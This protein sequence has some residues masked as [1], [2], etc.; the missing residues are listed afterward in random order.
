[1]THSTLLACECGAGLSV[2]TGAIAGVWL[3]AG[4]RRT[5]LIN[6]KFV[7][8]RIDFALKIYVH[9]PQYK[10]SHLILFSRKI[11]H[12]FG[13]RCN[14]SWIRDRQEITAL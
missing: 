10:Q 11:V 1:M 14:H 3:V 13:T 12:R 4:R 6:L 2:D 7:G 5:A 8:L 9:I